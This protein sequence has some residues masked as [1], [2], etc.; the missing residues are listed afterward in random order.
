LALMAQWIEP[1]ARE[2]LGS[3]W[4]TPTATYVSAGRGRARRVAG[5][6]SDVEA[7][8][9]EVRV[10]ALGVVWQGLGGFRVGG[11]AVLWHG[12]GGWLA[13]R[14]EGWAVPLTAHG[15]WLGRF[16]QRV[17]LPANER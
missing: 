13:R 15:V 1:P 5:A 17:P 16:D 3:L 6:A 9:V 10:P 12:R 4:T 11:A 14:L 2:P 8:L 7:M